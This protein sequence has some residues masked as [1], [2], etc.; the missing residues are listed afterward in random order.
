MPPGPPGSLVHVLCRMSGISAV[1][2]NTTGARA[3]F[4]VQVARGHSQYN[5]RLARP[6]TVTGQLCLCVG[7]GG[8]IQ[9]PK[10]LRQLWSEVTMGICQRGGRHTGRVRGQII[11]GLHS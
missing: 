4:E 2:K 3:E 11:G 8:S 5:L 6:A 10:G 9:P 1:R 7:P